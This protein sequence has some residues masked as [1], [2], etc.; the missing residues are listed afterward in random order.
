MFCS[1]PSLNFQSLQLVEHDLHDLLVYSRT[2]NVR[3]AIR[4]SNP[5]KMT[6]DSST[7]APAENGHAQTSLEAL[8]AAL[9][10]NEH[11]L[12]SSG[13][14]RIATAAL[15]VVKEVFDLGKLA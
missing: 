1:R 15:Q 2:N 12:A 6:Q 9:T 13:D 5:S 8:T 14:A 3:I 11:L 7:E 10:G 4:P